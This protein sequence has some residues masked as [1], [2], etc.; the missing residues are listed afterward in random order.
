MPSFGEGQ[1]ESR[2]QTV[3]IPLVIRSV[4]L[5]GRLSSEGYHWSLRDLCLG[6]TLRSQVTLTTLLHLQTHKQG[7][8]TLHTIQKANHKLEKQFLLN[9][10]GQFLIIIVKMLK[11]NVVKNDMVQQWP[12]SGQEGTGQGDSWKSQASKRTSAKRRAHVRQT[13]PVPPRAAT[14]EGETGALLSQRLKSPTMSLNSMIHS[15]KL[16]SC[17]SVNLGE[18]W[19]SHSA[20]VL[21]LL[22]PLPPQ[23]EKAS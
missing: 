15:N 13:L 6:P 4:L 3:R 20:L 18:S 7:S 19:P 2:P 21:R 22:C 16:D 11:L 23:R 1:E 9:L 8:H 12:V 5:E 17:S 10:E 14:Q